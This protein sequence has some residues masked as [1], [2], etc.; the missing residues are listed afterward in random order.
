MYPGIKKS[1]IMQTLFKNLFN[2]IRLLKIS[3]FVISNKIFQKPSV[4][5][6]LRYQKINFLTT[7]ALSSYWNNQKG[8]ALVITLL[9]LVIITALV[10]EFSYG[11]YTGTSDLY[12]WRDSQRLSVMAKSGVNVSAKYLLELLSTTYKDY[13]YP[14]FIEMP[15]ENPF[16]DFEGVI[17]VRIEDENSKFNLNSITNP[18]WFSSFQRLLSILSLDTRIA[19][20]VLD[21]IDSNSE[22]ELSDSEIGAKNSPLLT[23]DELL[24]ING[25][26][27]EDYDKLLP[28]VT[29]YGD[30]SAH[31]INI[32]GA[33]APV[34]MS[35]PAT[36]GGFPITEDL[37]NRI[38]Q[39]RESTPF[40]SVDDLKNVLGFNDDL[41]MSLGGKITVQGKVFSIK[42][43]AASGGV[44]RIIETVFEDSS[45]KLKYWKEY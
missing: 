43:T 5:G 33:E 40:Q 24:L 28:Y 42:S 30:A 2:L 25:I 9:V 31:Q 36:G 8:I 6:T 3:L 22:P 19:K 26:S 29:V 13:S 18:D 35:I 38:I 20:R 10:V 23:V 17:T 37:A 12:N 11:V 16:E 21:W 34:L 44:K 32:N 45:H 15:V 27:R 4:K 41:R 1:R 39:Y 14:G 7:S